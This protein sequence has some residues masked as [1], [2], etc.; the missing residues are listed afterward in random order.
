MG[1]QDEGDVR[2]ANQGCID[3]LQGDGRTA[4]LDLGIGVDLGNR[5]IA[6]GEAGF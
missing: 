3:T 2:F 1:L 4:S 5:Q 6:E